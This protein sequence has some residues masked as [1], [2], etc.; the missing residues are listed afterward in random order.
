MVNKLS[1]RGG[2]PPAVALTLI[3]LLVVIAIIGIL[4]AMLLG[5]ISRAKNRAVEMIDVNNLKQI[6][7]A[8][9]LYVTDNHDNLPW[10]NWKSGDHGGRPGWLYTLD[11]T[12][13]GPAQFKLNLGLLW[14]TL[15]HPTLYFCPMDDTNSPL[16]AQR[17]Q[18]LSSY[19]INGAIVGYDR[20]NYPAARSTSLRP[21][22]I[23]FWETD[24]TQPDYFNDGANFPTEGVSSRHL[25]GAI[26]ASF[27]GAV[28][29][30]RLGAWYLQVYDT[31]KN[32]LWCY[33]GSANGR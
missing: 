5:S 12:A 25:N 2:I 3:E 27:G 10:A 33:P 16:F 31:N 14:P 6:G 13:T 15:L 26:N 17:E 4:S 22:D 29:Y 24:E 7:L 9:Q 28:T 19:A 11:P 18:Q 23:A 21:D 32:N 20:T 8:V 30:V 1:Q